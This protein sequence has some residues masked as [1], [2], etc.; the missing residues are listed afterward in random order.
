MG[1]DR[2][3]M[4]HLCCWPCRFCFCMRF[5]SV[6]MTY[7]QNAVKEIQMT[8][9]AVWAVTWVHPTILAPANGF[10]PWAAFLKA[11]SAVISSTNKGFQTFIT[12]LFFSHL[13]GY[14]CI[15]VYIKP[16]CMPTILSKLYF[17]AAVVCQLDVFDAEVPVPFGVN[18]LSVSKKDLILKIFCIWTPSKI[19]NKIRKETGITKKYLNCLVWISR[20]LPELLLSVEEWEIEWDSERRPVFVNRLLNSC[21]C[22]GYWIC[23]GKY[24]YIYYI[25]YIKYVLNY[26]KDKCRPIYVETLKGLILSIN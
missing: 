24:T 19:G 21:V 3:F 10:S 26:I 15:C 8:L 2:G 22:S 11:I 12:F 23:W 4:F 5:F 6:C 9:T 18:L 16:Y 20:H 1:G 13:A 25:F 14:I 7:N 17:S